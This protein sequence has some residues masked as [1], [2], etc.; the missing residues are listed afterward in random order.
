MRYHNFSRIEKMP[1][2][3]LYAKKIDLM[4]QR[5]S[6]TEGKKQKIEYFINQTFP[7]TQLFYPE[8]K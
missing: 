8:S 4:A 2:R 7:A 6:L 5:Q 3:L 1:K